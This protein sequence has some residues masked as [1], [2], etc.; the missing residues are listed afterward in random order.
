ML[1]SF[2]FLHENICCGYSLE[3]P[4]Q[5]ASNEYPQHMFSWGNKK[6]IMWIPPLICSYVKYSWKYWFSEDGHH[7]KGTRVHFSSAGI[8]ENENNNKPLD[9]VIA[10]DKRRYHIIFFLFLDEYICCGYSLEGP[11]RGASNEY[12]Q[13]KFLLRNKKDI[14]IFRM[15]KAPYLLLC[16]VKKEIM[17]LRSVGSMNITSI[18]TGILKD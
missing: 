7:M 15:K 2:L 11:C 9:L 17:T 18:E 16:L 13:H 12:A 14:S 10:T 3:A 1:I 6:N 5:G 8:S 4:W